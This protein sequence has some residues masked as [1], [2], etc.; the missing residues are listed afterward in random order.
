M[1]QAPGRRT[2]RTD[3]GAVEP[4]RAVRAPTIPIGRSGI[5]RYVPWIVAPMAY[6][7]VLALAVSVVLT[8]L[9]GVW[10]AGLSG[11][12]T[13]QIP[14]Q[15]DDLAESRAIAAAL[16]IVE[17]VPGVTDAALLDPERSRALLEPWLG[18]SGALETLRLPLLIDVS[19]EAE[20]TVDVPALAERLAGAVAGA[21]VTDH[22]AW[23]ANLLN[24]A[25]T[26]RLVAWAVVASVGVAAAVTV[27]FVT[28]AGLSI[29]RG[30]LDVLHVL[31]ASDG[32]IARQFQR[33]AFLAVVQGG[34]AGLLL[35]GGTLVL[36]QREVAALDSG[37]M[38]ALDLPPLVWVTMVLIPLA[39]GALALVT[40][41]ATVFL[42]LA[43]EP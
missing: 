11:Q 34:L 19:T 27:V 15:P 4:Y 6:L 3:A 37:L 31:G 8:S 33:H 14:A 43:R 21:E 13:I 9:I 23:M 12:L 28:R 25:G 36:L 20:A 7:A 18:T 41:R 35:A 40:A 10:D 24:V 17:S 1:A 29:H 30:T 26:L 42:M 16:E 32:F 5:G 39:L 38:P 22:D 2:G